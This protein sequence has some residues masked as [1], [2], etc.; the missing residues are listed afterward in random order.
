MPITSKHSARAAKE[1]LEAALK[2]QVEGI[3]DRCSGLYSFSIAERLVREN[4]NEGLR[5]WELYI[6]GIEA[7][8]EAGTEQAELF[9]GEISDALSDLC[10]EQPQA[11]EL[12]PGRT[13][14]RAWH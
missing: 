10:N 6:S 5:E 1:A 13:F 12:L 14:A 7:Y 3:F 4:P 11:A 2:A 9:V 8:P